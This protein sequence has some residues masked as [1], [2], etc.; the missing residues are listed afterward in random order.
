MFTEA[1]LIRLCRILL[2]FLNTKQNMTPYVADVQEDNPIDFILKVM[3]AIAD[4]RYSLPACSP[5]TVDALH[6]LSRSLYRLT[7]YSGLQ[8]AIDS[9]C[10]AT[11]TRI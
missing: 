5:F 3:A 9:L 1:I 2:P 6:S 10:Q 4:S 8:L 11:L 7:L